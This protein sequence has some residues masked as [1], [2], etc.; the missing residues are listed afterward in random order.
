MLVSNLLREEEILMKKI[1][2][3]AEVEVKAFEL[4]DVITVSG[5]NQGGSGNPNCPYEMPEEGD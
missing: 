5:G 4:E 3:E 2:T 1:F